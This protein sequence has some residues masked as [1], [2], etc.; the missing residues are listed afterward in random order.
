MH[1]SR[2][3][4]EEPS[5]IFS[6]SYPILGQKKLSFLL[7]E[8]ESG[9]TL[10]ANE[11]SVT[12]FD[13][14]QCTRWVFTMLLCFEYNKK[15]SYFLLNPCRKELVVLPKTTVECNVISCGLG[16]NSSSGREV[17]VEFLERGN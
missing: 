15:Q 3:K 5:M 16:F 17:D 1:T 8:E 7:V 14:N 11:S 13:L 4:D 10:K 6:I 12:E 9:R 2:G